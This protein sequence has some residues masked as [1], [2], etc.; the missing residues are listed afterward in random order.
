MNPDVELTITTPIRIIPSV[1]G[2]L[3]IIEDYYG[4]NHY[5]DKDGTYD[6]WSKDTEI[7]NEN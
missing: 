2:Y 5:F 1:A 7:P 6:G 4:V 3:L